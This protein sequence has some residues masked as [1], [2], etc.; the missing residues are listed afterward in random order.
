MKKVYLLIIPIMVIS[1]VLPAKILA[2]GQEQHPSKKEVTKSVD[3][4]ATNTAS[5]NIKK[6]TSDTSK[7]KVLKSGP[8]NVPTEGLRYLRE[9]GV[10]ALFLLMMGIGFLG[11]V[12]HSR[13]RD[14]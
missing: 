11:F 5:S 10:L 14:V 6:D 1:L 4:P 3:K 2:H 9:G 12:G 8:V 7:N 13:R